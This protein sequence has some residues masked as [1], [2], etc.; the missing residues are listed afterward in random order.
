MLHARLGRP[1]GRAY[2]DLSKAWA[3]CRR[4]LQSSGC[5]E[6]N[7]L[8]NERRQ[9]HST[10]SSRQQQ[11]AP[12]EQ[13]SPVSAYV[14]LPFCKRRCYYCD[15]PVSV[16]GSKPEQPGIQQGMQ[17]YIT[18][19]C[20]EI[21]ATVKVPG[22]P[23]RTVFFGGGTPTLVPPQ[24]LKQ[25][26][27]ALNNKC[28]QIQH[29]GTMLSAGVARALWQAVSASPTHISVY[30][31]QAQAKTPFARWYEPGSHPMP[32]DEAT[33]DMYRAASQFLQQSG[34]EHYEISNYAK[35]GFRS[36]H[37]LG[38]WRNAPF[39]AF[40]VGAASYLFQ[41]RFSRPRT[42]K[43]YQQWVTEFA[44]CSSSIGLYA[45][46][47]PGSGSMQAEELEEQLL[48]YVML[49]L[50]LADGIPMDELQR[51]FGHVAAQ[52]VK[53][54]LASGS[55]YA[56]NRLTNQ[57]SHVEKGTTAYME[58]NGLHVTSTAFVNIRGSAQGQ[59]AA[60]VKS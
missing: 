16:V 43:A 32:T 2:A 51:K 23:L 13:E 59:P 44:N 15:F 21:E 52:T 53:A 24:L 60:S 11:Q 26:L 19:L 48:D 6:H 37:N 33:A 27:I 12:M 36:Q 40:G 56:E 29:G 58:P 46:N 22:P 17:D 28:Q 41:R 38:Y 49:R 7:K 30:D 20:R 5:P 47:I 25:I 57:A 1:L 50:R 45:G 55:A 54:T 31:L 9:S 4:S 10:A 18:L 35:P 8:L 39:Y 3:P 14:H 42:M 34:Y